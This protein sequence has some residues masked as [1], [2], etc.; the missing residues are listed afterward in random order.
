VKCPVC[1]QKTIKFHQW[2][3]AEN[4]FNWTCRNCGSALK[5]NRI[6]TSTYWLALVLGLAGCLFVV[7][8]WHEEDL[9]MI[10]LIFAVTAVVVVPLGAVAWFFGG[11]EEVTA[12]EEDGISP[13]DKSA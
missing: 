6:V 9:A 5:A 1:N 13:H 7:I 2:K 4:A 11:Y 10:G 8:R 3:K 12:R